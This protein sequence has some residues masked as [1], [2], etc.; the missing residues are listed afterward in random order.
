MDKVAD[1]MTGEFSLVVG[2]PL[3]QL[4]RRAYLTGDTLELLNRW[5]P[6]TSLLAWLP[7]LVQRR[8]Q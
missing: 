1:F 4:L 2:G 8:C 7:L 6:V 3:F 5:I